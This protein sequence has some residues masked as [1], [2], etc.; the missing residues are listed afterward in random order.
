M[1]NLLNSTINSI[2]QLAKFNATLNSFFFW[3]S[4]F[5]LV[6]GI[7]AIILTKDFKYISLGSLLVIFLIFRLID[8]LAG[9]G[10]IESFFILIFNI[11]KLFFLNIKI[12]TIILFLISLLLIIYKSITKKTDR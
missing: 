12:I 9:S 4:A 1:Y 3:F 10:I 7:I 5:L 8:F 11:L 6:I 2:D